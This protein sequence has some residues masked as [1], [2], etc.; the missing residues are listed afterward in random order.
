MKYRNIFKF[1][2]AAVLSI[3]TFACTQEKFEEIS[4]LDLARC[5]EPMN[6]EA[7]VNAALGD[8]VTFSWDVSKDAEVYLLSIYTDAAHT[9]ASPNSPFT[10]E[11]SQVPYTLKLEEG[12]YYFT[13]QACKEG[14]IDSKIADYGKTIKTYAVKNNLYL[15]LADR[16]S[17][18]LSL[19]W[20]T[21]V[22]D[23]EDVD[24]IVYRAPGAEDDEQTKNLTADEIAAGEATINGLA[25]GSQY[26]VML[27]YKSASRGQICVWTA[28][29]TEG[30]TEVS[31]LEGLQNAVKTPDAKIYLLL[32]GS[33]YDIEAMDIAN[34]LTLTGEVDVDGN[35][36]VLQG[37]LQIADTW[38][39]QNLYF[40]NVCFDGSPTAASPSGFGF[41]IQN[42]NGGTVDGKS[43]GDLVYT[44]CVITNYSKGLFYEWGKAVSLKKVAYLSC[45]ITNINADGTGGGDV[46][47]IRQATS[48]ES[49]IFNDC[50]VMQGMRTFV[51]IDAGSINAFEFENNTL[52]N[53]NF[54]ENAN[55]AGVFGFQIVPGSFSFKN[56]LFLNMTGKAIL[57]SANAKYKTAS[58]MSA[59]ASGN[60][61]WS[62]P[63]DDKGEV[64]YFTD[65]F[66][67]AQAG[68]TILADSP[69]YNA[70]G[71]YFNILAS[72]DIAGKKIGASKWWTPYVEEPEDLTMELVPVPH[73]WN[74][75]NAKYFSGNIKKEMVRD[76]LFVS[77]SEAAPISA[78]NGMLNF[79]SA[80]IT[81]RNGVP[82]HN[83]VAFHTDVPGSLVIKA[84][85]PGDYT[86]HLVVGVGPVDGTSIALKGG[87]S[88]LSEQGNATKI[89]ITS[90]TEESIVYVY[91]SG[92]VSLSQLSWTADLTPVNTA[93][94]TPAPKAAPASF[95]AGEATDVVISWEPVDNAA[96][97]SVV[98]SGKTYK[99]E[100]CT[101]TIEGKTTSMLDPGSYTVSVYANP[102][103]SDIYN[104]ESVAGTAAFAV[105][106]AGGGAGSDEFIV[107]SV[108]DLM[109]AIDAGK[110]YITLKYSDAVYEIGK[111]TL[112]APLHLKGQTSGDKKTAINASFTLS[113]EIGGS[114]VL[115][116]L[117]ITSSDA[118]TAISVLIEDKTAAPIADTVAVYDS[119]LHGTKA[120]YDNSGKAASNVQWLIFKGNLI[121]DSSAGADYID[122][123]TGAHHNFVF[124]NNTV[125]NSCRT[126]VRTDKTHEMNTALIK[127]NTFYKVAT[128]STSKDNN[129]I[130]HIRSEAGAGLYDYRLE[131]NFF[132][133]ILFA[134]KPGHDN[135]FPK[136]KSGGGL[137]PNVIR[138]NYFFNCEDREEWAAYS[139]WKN[140]SKEDATAQGGAILPAD[141]CKAAEAGD[142]TLTNAVMM[143][144]G[145]GDPRWNS[146]AGS[147]PTSEITVSDAEAFLTAIAAGKKVITLEAGVYDFTTEAANALEEVTNSK[148]TLVAPLSIIGQ[149]GAVLKAGFIFNEGATSFSA[150]N[151]T[152]D[153][154][155]AVDNAFEI[156]QAAVNMSSFSV[157]NCDITAYK[158]R[159]FYMNQTGSVNSVE[160][161]N[162][163][164]TGAQDGDK[165]ANFTGGDFI[166]VRKGTMTA[167]KVRNSTFANAIRTFARIDA[168]VVCGSILVQNNT[169]YNLCFVDSKDNNGVF[170]VR[171]TSVTSAGQVIVKDNL[172]A[173]MH[174]AAENPS[175]AQGFPK[176]VSKAS[177][178][179]ALPAFS[180]NYFADVLTTENN[181]DAEYSWW[182][183]SAKEVAT[184]GYGVVLTADVFANAEAGDFT[185][186]HGL[187]ASEK[188]GDPRWIKS[189]PAAGESFTVANIEELATALDAGKTVLALTGAEYDL[190]TLETATNGSI[191][192]N[193]GV[194]FIGV[195]HNGVKPEVK[196]G[197]I[198]ASTEGDFVLD[199]IRLN[200]VYVKD[201]KENKVGNMI[202]INAATNAGAIILR[203]SEVY[204]YANRLVSGSGESAI[205]AL[206]LESL[207]VH[208]FGTGGD[209]IDFRKGSV[210]NIKVSSSTFYNGIRTFLRVDASVNT[211]AV[212]VQNNTFYNLCSVDSKDNNGI[213]HVRSGSGISPASLN[214]AARRVMVSKNIFAAM[215]KAAE[216]PSQANGFPK[217]VSTASEKLAHPYVTDNLFFDIEAEGSYSWWNTMTAEDIE[218]AGTVLTET[219][220]SADPATGKF[221]V[222]SSYKGYGDTRW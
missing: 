65:S 214:T 216:T 107:S 126:F 36:P 133:S 40:E 222:K 97:Y 188:V 26:E 25:A 92:P 142:F 122:L 83:F 47:D 35:M 213:L 162:V 15:K 42:K 110:D 157:K 24:R 99:V 44:N 206:E 147:T 152:L 67:M 130:L 134:E 68:G 78:A 158:N 105:L 13:V 128:N 199:G 11:P 43:I 90:I 37:E 180:H 190:T 1:A 79:G 151:L 168:S 72:S 51:R 149:E 19:K 74:L 88:A 159:L 166:D 205:T 173:S 143:N 115:R 41:A 49:L 127:N 197:F 178:A 118:G 101:Y 194:T 18:S 76:Y 91:P 96:S 196:G 163:M 100:E 208:D 38:N 111:L 60:Y 146:M 139:F 170:H 164:V 66:S 5:L 113:G 12:N 167:L 123:R 185:V 174:R 21:E 4:E 14:K 2:V 184:A 108:E 93:L 119:N 187:V 161:D 17:T 137:V 189:A 30:F 71:G 56:N 103:D 125:A 145:V 86:G 172:F 39:G 215:H 104:T 89:L 183:Y 193:K 70:A 55:N 73:T 179:I 3:G 106:P 132:Y 58:D 191:T 209:F 120:L 135:G 95:T 69:C 53:L 20:S 59:S 46:F 32:A 94:P 218:A 192:L 64:I 27:F 207:L 6:L 124:E 81:N 186:V 154:G 160:F 150:N 10:L 33:P 177:S 84:E 169:F 109:S 28:A 165:V 204:G 175:Q 202:D 50:T 45:D 48:M 217:L 129:G 61:F 195:S 52:Y 117:D 75:A 144:A 138:N 176:L 16:T 121:T 9:A 87:V 148:I 29:N 34:G 198:L 62:L 116:N 210:G 8:V 98:F 201:D 22:A 212:T 220:F 171:S 181:T 85:N 77:G 219:P 31:T 23:F 80:V 203:N 7:K 114:V 221:T 200:G 131:N 57:A 112:N 156:A 136:L 63:V 153:G 182:A 155:F 140:L 102:G 141:P 54:V 211:G 82:Q